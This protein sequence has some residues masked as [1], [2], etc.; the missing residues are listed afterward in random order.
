MDEEL[1]VGEVISGTVSVLTE[2]FR[3]FAIFV[4][5]MT[6]LGSA[7]E[8]GL[9][10]YAWSGLEFGQAT[11]VQAW[12]GLGAGVAGLIV[13][14]VAILAQYLLWDAVLRNVVLETRLGRHRY[15][16]FFGLTIFTAFAISIG[17]VFLIVPGLLLTAR[18][19]MAP[20]VLIGED[21]GVFE[22]MGESWETVRGNSTPI[23]LAILL[24]FFVYLLL[25]GA[26][27]GAAL[28]TSGPV[29]MSAGAIISGQLL[30]NFSTA[31][32]V[33]LGL[34][35]YKRLRSNAEQ[36]AGVFA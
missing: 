9:T 34:F 35:L 36:V 22:A 23:I 30:T 3:P 4:G 25:A 5:A 27:G 28:L 31:L 17:Y 33:A 1:N 32:G 7:I 19:A 20:A 16:S 24:Y 26:V 21:K 11:M 18:W 29:G 8:I 14:V 15:L 2:N 10:S 12:L 6:L 13:F